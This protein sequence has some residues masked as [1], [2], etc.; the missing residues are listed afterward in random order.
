MAGDQE[1]CIAAGCDGFLA[2]PVDIDKLMPTLEYML[3]AD[4]TPEDDNETRQVLD[5]NLGDLRPQQWTS[6]EPKGLD[7]PM[8]TGVIFP[9]ASDPIP[10]AWELG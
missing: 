9:A 6:V 4:P 1:K 8:T 2:K 3:E 5:A 10:N 7:V